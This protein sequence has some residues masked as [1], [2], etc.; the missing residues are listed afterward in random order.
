MFFRPSGPAYEALQNIKRTKGLH[1]VRF[2]LRGKGKC[3]KLIIGIAQVHPVLSGRFAWYQ[4]RRIANVQAE[5]YEA[6][7]VLH[8]RVGVTSFGLEGYSG[9]GKA[10]L[11]KEFLQEMNVASGDQKEVKRILRTAAK[12]WR[13]ALHRGNNKD[14]ST[15]A[16]MLN[17]LTV[18]QAAK[19]NVSVYPIE[20]AQVHGAI[21]QA[22]TQL[23]QSIAEVEASSAYKRMQKKGGKGLTRE[24][25]EAAKVRNGLVKEFN[26]TIAHPER[27]RAI[28]REVL[29]HAQSPVTVFVLGA[30]HRSGMLTLAAKHL[31]DGYLFAWAS[32]PAFWWK[33]A[34]LYRAGWVLIVCALLFFLFAT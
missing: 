26:K 23:Q 21:G 19:D 32:P 18:L 13:R 25:F 11:P 3:T 12:R 33:K 24:E 8:D 1:R 2:R 34:M 6:C 10:R 28:L 16:T 14:A 31:P 9:R 29:K 27:D 22:L 17:A 15:Y 20:Q 30:G 4:A 7:R 5:I